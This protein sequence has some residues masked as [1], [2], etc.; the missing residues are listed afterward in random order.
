MQ[1]LYFLRTSQTEKITIDGDVVSNCSEIYIKNV[2][3]APFIVDGSTVAVGET[4]SETTCTPW[5]VNSKKYRIVVTVSVPK[6][7]NVIE[8]EVKRVWYMP[9]KGEFPPSFNPN[10]LM[11]NENK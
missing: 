7:T 11:P 4:Y 3:T 1:N 10:L 8:A 9:T 2:G 5:A 6:G